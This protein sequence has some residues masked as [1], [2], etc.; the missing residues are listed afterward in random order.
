M[1]QSR[2]NVFL[3]ISSDLKTV[4][5]NLK[6][7]PMKK[8]ILLITLS[9]LPFLIHAQESCEVIDVYEVYEAQRSVKTITQEGNLIE[10]RILLV[11]ISIGKGRH[12]ASV[13]KVGNNVY[14][15]EH[16]NMYIETE[17]CE[18]QAIKQP[19]ELIIEENRKL[20][21]GKIIFNP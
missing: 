13:T 7:S 18:V 17:A 3:I 5:K 21:S 2:I 11:S 20:S 9:F 19:A 15:M 4:F 14:M 1:C 6:V 12:D 8:S 10:A 16:A